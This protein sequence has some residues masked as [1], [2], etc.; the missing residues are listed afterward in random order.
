MFLKPLRKPLIL[1]T[2][3]LSL[4]FLLSSCVSS[5]IPL[6]ENTSA[7]VYPSPTLEY[8]PP[9]G[10]AALEYTEEAILTLPMHD[11]VRLTS[12]T[13]EIPFSVVR[14]RAES[15]VRSLL[16]HPG[17]GEA[18][19]LGG[20][21]KLALYGVNPVETSRNVATVNLAASAL[22]LSRKEYYLACQA[23]TDTL[24][25]LSEI[26]YVNFLVMDKP[27]ALDIGG[28]L[29]SGAFT[30]SVSSNI[31]TVYD[32]LLTQRSNPSET[33]ASPRLS[34]VATLYFPLVGMDGLLA[35]A[36]TVSFDD[37]KPSTIVLT[38]LQEL[39]K[40]PQEKMDSPPLPLL[41]DLLTQEPILTDAPGGGGQIVTLHFAYNLDDMLATFGLTR[42]G[43]MASIC[44]TLSSFLPN[45]T[46]IRATIGDT[47]LG[48][49]RLVEGSPQIALL[50]QNAVQR[51]SDYAAFVMDFSTLYFA[52]ENGEKLMTVQR[53][54]PYYQTTNPRTLLLQ[55]S[56]GPLPI[57]STKTA[58]RL[59]PSNTLRDSDLLGF[60]LKD[61]VLL[62]HF[63]PTFR[64]LGY[65]LS[66][67]ED[68]LLAYGLVN[69]LSSLPKI[70]RVVFYMSN[71]L[72]PSFTDAIHWAGAF[73]R[74]LGLV[75]K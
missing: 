15:L 28:T 8:P 46:G 72:P 45:V 33:S 63:T 57:D 16:N 66:A 60:A 68:R 14:P 29:P 41:S 6:R 43:S 70:Q 73:Y 2:G 1:T 21:T 23:I 52:D 11:G 17:N 20:K 37:Q 54:V 31:G 24:T 9:I 38:L 49:V 5:G 10:D 26:Q 59:M 34:A 62:V 7:L 67:Q 32:Q 19:P 55:L 71:E 42:A 39:A 4:C 51:R 64:N 58:K 56:Q 48:N 36:R 35:E 25:H 44:Y 22:Q 3:L 61:D 12:F 30:Q 75:Q 53:P 69:T 13:E 40:G 65:A 18:A 74:N 47:L 50:F 27:I